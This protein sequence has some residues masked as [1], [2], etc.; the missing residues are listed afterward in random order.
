MRA[1]YTVYKFNLDPADDN[2]GLRS[3]NGANSIQLAEIE[4]FDAGG[5]VLRDGLTCTNPGG[6]NPGGEL[7]EHACNGATSNDPNGC[8]GCAN[9]GHKWLDFNSKIAH[10]LDRRCPS[11]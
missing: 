8:S 7:P 11:R 6:S 10:D 2:T 4:L 3:W 1:Q 9:S 5:N